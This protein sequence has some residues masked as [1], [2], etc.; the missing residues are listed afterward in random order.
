MKDRMSTTSQRKRQATNQVEGK[1][2]K[3]GQKLKIREC[4]CFAYEVQH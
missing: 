4:Q 3:Q 1:I 2:Y